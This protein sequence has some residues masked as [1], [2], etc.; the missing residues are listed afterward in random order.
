MGVVVHLRLAARLRTATRL[1][2][3]DPDQV[4]ISM[5]EGEGG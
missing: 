1:G 3:T 5:A 2:D 4:L